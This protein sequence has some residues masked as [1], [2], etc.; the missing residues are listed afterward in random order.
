MPEQTKKKSF[1][2]HDLPSYERP[3]ERLLKLGPEA[4][5]AQEILALV[6][7]SGIAGESVI[8][9][10]Q[11]LLSEF[12]NLSGI[13]NASIEELSKVKGIGVAKATQLQAS[14]ELA[15]RLEESYLYEREGKTVRTP[16][17]AVKRVKSRLRGKKKEH[18]LVLLLNTRNQLI[19]TSEISIGSLDTS[20]VHPREVFKEAISASASSCIFIHN[21]PSGDP[22]PSLDDIELTK[23]LIEAGGIVGIDVRDHIIITDKDFISLRE[24]GNIW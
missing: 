11:R 7:G 9:T 14:F 1:T 19:T 15:K 2:V 23:R 17:D 3:R 10:A 21:H 20:I 24:R 6:L 18:F 4:L 8:I 13:A 5:S 12:G 22:T 16:E